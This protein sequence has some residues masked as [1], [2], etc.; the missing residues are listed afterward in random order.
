M[1]ILER[2]DCYRKEHAERFRYFLNEVTKSVLDTTNQIPDER[3]KQLFKSQ[4]RRVIAI[5]TEKYHGE[6][7]KE[8]FIRVFFSI[9]K[10]QYAFYKWND[11]PAKKLDSFL[12][13]FYPGIICMQTYKIDLYKRTMGFVFQFD[14][15]CIC[16][17]FEDI[18]G[19]FNDDIAELLQS[20][21]SS[22]NWV[23]C[24]LNQKEKKTAT[25][26][27]AIK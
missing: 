1:N 10:K 5:T 8:G 3:V 4:N 22:E 27:I 17:E 25:I 20:E 19:V 2:Y 7:C 12:K 14:T 21:F 23:D 24:K 18:L 9:E 16:K 15:D 13:E 26:A 6:E 11:E